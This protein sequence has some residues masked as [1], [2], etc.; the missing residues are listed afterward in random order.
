MAEFKMKDTVLQKCKPSADETDIVIPAGVTRIAPQ[1]F[2]KLKTI[3]TVTIPETV[4]KIG[5]RAF[6][7][8]P[9]LAAVAIMPAQSPDTGLKHI[10]YQAFEGCQQLAVCRLPE[11][12]TK[13]E[14][15]A[16]SG[17]T[18]LRE[19]PLPDGLTEVS[20]HLLSCC[21]SITKAVIPA[22]MTTVP[23]QMFSGCVNLSEVT[24]HE[25]VTEINTEAFKDCKN[26]HEITLPESLTLISRDAFSGSGIR[27]LRIP[28][29]VSI[30][31]NGFRNCPELTEIEF[32]V[33]PQKGT[34]IR[35]HLENILWES[36]ELTEVILRG[37]QVPQDFR[38]FLGWMEKERHSNKEEFPKDDDRPWYEALI[39]MLEFDDYILILDTDHCVSMQLYRV[40]GSK[41][42]RSYEMNNSRF[43][44]TTPYDRWESTFKRMMDNDQALR[45]YRYETGK[46]TE[47]RE[48]S[49]KIYDSWVYD[50]CVN[51]VILR[52]EFGLEPKEEKAKADFASN[53]EKAEKFM[54]TLVYA[55]YVDDRSAILE[56]AKTASKTALNEKFEYF[57]TPLIFCAKHDFLEGFK[58]IAKRGGD[59][60]KRI[61]GG[62][63]SPIGEALNNSPAITLYIAQE[64]PEAF[65]AF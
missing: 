42:E 17:C 32:A 65:D 11:T 40:I 34:K 4:T 22:G 52:N 5:N 62:T 10:E 61:V 31:A 19:M 56:R 14:R 63:V 18:A 43:G 55:C 8:C 20:D 16:F 50:G 45:A 30:L 44:K 59:I 53:L 60:T 54:Q 58:A 33:F 12:V 27:R 37:N 28:A 25:G 1:A 64:H 6:E 57:G 48:L 13:I 51:A 7:L 24:V 29:N 2:Y 3:R 46:L 47:I 15:W 36:P 35:E 26:L 9:V 41:Y 23:P 39:D 21:E 38:D 49:R